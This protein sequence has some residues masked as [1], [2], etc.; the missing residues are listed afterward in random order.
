MSGA[1]CVGCGGIVSGRN[2]E[3]QVKRWSRV[4]SRPP[5]YPRIYRLVDGLPL[6]SSCLADWRVIGEVICCQ[7]GRDLVYHSQKGEK[8]DQSPIEN[9]FNRQQER[10]MCKDCLAAE[11]KG[12]SLLRNRGLLHYDECGKAWLSRFKYRGDERMAAFFSAL[13]AIGYYRSYLSARFSCVTEVPLHESRLTERGF[14]QME[15]VAR[16]LSMRTGIPYIPL[17]IRSKQTAK[18]SQQRGK[19]EREESLRGAFACMNQGRQIHGIDSRKQLREVLIVDD[20]YTTGSTLRACALAIQE[21]LGRECR[22][23]ALTCF[24]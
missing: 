11:E 3:E 18:L 13:L 8:N 5:T 14:N 12:Q 17:L 16:G 6:C 19:R 4:L 24:R 23:S 20:I 10:R 22:V 2:R 7:C 15:L 21:E 1:G 9:G